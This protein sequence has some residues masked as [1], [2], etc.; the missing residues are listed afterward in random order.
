MPAPA[1]FRAF[2][3]TGGL[4]AALSGRAQPTTAL[5]IPYL[6]EAPAIDGQPDDWPGPPAA[7]WRVVAH[8]SGL[9][10]RARVWLGRDET[11]LYAL[12]RIQ[13][14]YLVRPGRGTGNPRLYFNDAVELYVDA[15]GDRRRVLDVNDYQF[16]LDLAGDYVIFKG[17]KRERLEGARV[18]KDFGTA[19]LLPRVAATRQG[20]VNQL[21]DRDSGYVVEV[22]VPCAGLG[23]RPGPGHRL[24]LDACVEDMDSVFDLRSFPEG[25]PL[26]AYSFES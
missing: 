26:H 8:R 18:P 3:L 17:D 4:L 9:R 7:D 13:D 11:N 12:Y 14:T 5:P 19:T 20:T 1:L 25:R 15:P 2:L 6:A 24:R 23:V 16:I 10:N 22:A 21:A